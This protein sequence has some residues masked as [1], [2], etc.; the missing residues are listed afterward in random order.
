M[1]S[2]NTTS[3]EHRFSLHNMWRAA[4]KRANEAESKITE[5]KAQLSAGCVTLAVQKLGLDMARNAQKPRSMDEAPAE[6]Q[7]IRVVQEGIFRK[8]NG[9]GDQVKY[10][11]PMTNEAD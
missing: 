3:N 2:E 6:G 1:N 5:L 10:W 8:A 4:E 11:L 9:L 7:R